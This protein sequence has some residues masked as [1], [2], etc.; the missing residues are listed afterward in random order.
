ME[1]DG[2]MSSLNIPIRIGPLEFG[3]LGGGW[4]SV[5]ARHRFG[6]TRSRRSKTWEATS[7][8]R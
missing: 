1:P 7:A 2:D 3:V 6:R 8:T 4:S 5:K